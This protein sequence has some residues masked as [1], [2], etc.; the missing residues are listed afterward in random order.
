MA[1]HRITT[2][3]VNQGKELLR[4]LRSPDR[5]MLTDAEIRMV[6]LQLHLLDIELSNR[7]D[8]EL[9]NRQ[10]R[11]TPSQKLPARAQ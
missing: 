7:L 10:N 6:R 8:I 3:F 5:T 2:E 1:I 11:N 4:Q 9:S